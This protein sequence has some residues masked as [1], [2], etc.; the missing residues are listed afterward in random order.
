MLTICVPCKGGP[1]EL[2]SSSG[3]SSFMTRTDCYSTWLLEWQH[4][5]SFCTSGFMAHG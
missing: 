4:A 5:G 2:C 1:K 3:C